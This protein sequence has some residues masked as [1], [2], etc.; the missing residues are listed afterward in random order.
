M[1]FFVVRNVARK[2][3]NRVVRSSRLRPRYAQRGRCCW[4]AARCFGATSSSRRE[5]DAYVS[6]GFPSRRP[7]ASWPLGRNTRRSASSDVILQS[8]RRTRRQKGRRAK[9][10]DLVCSPRHATVTHNS[11]QFC[12]FR[13]HLIRFVNPYHPS[14]KVPCFLK[15]INDLEMEYFNMARPSN[16]CVLLCAFC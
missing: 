2:V 11:S 16:N 4:P 6:W 14:Y 13:R 12:G 10:V 3:R 15:L 7:T 5:R 1:D 9:A 8:S